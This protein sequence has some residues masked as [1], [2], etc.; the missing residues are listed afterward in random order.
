MFVDLVPPKSITSI[1]N[2][3]TWVRSRLP[4]MS[5]TH[6]DT[7]LS[8]PYKDTC[9]H[10]SSQGVKK[11]EDRFVLHIRVWMDHSFAAQAHLDIHLR[12]STTTQRGQKRV[13]TNTWKQQTNMWGYFLSFFSIRCEFDW[14]QMVGFVGETQTPG[15]AGVGWHLE[16]CSFTQAPPLWVNLLPSYLLPFSSPTAT[17]IFPCCLVPSHIKDGE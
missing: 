16:V 11:K 1:K 7:I 10:L 4:I 13:I 2:Q 15:K 5:I 9:L 17:A 14:M 3:I 6:S 8:L 12:T